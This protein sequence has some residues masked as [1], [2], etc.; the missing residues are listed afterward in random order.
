MAPLSDVGVAA[1]GAG[2]HSIAVFETLLPL[3]IIDLPVAPLV[4]AFA[5]GLAVFEVAEIGIVIWIAFE[6]TAVPEVPGPLTFKL[7]SVAVP[8]YAL[9]MP[10]LNVVVVRFRINLSN[11]QR[12]LVTAVMTNFKS[13]Q[14]YHH[15]KVNL[16]RFNHKMVLLYYSFSIHLPFILQ[17]L[18]RIVRFNVQ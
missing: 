4:D 17:L 2:P 12:I 3:T 9:S 11:I 10:H 1:V 5:V 14:C 18:I 8:H 16:R 7:P 6:A 15:L 13:R